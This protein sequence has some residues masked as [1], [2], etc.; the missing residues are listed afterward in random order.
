[1]KWIIAAALLLAL[2]L[3]AAAQVT[4][5]AR[6]TS[7]VP[8]SDTSCTDPVTGFVAACQTGPTPIAP[9]VTAALANFLVVKGSAGALFSVYASNL[10]GGASGNLLVFNSATLPADGG[11]KQP[12]ICAPFSGGVAS[13]NYL[14][15]PPATFSAGITA[16]VSSAASCFTLTTG[17]LTA[18]ISG[19]AR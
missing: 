2:A 16:A 17:V 13:A 14:G 18:F 5:A 19:M 9:V 12:V 3:P 1:M 10:T 8:Q 4:P 11:S 6:S 15:L 7:Y